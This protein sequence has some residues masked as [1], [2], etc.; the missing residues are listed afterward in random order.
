MISPTGSG[1]AADLLDARGH[2]L[3]LRLGERQPVDERRVAAVFP[4]L[5]H[6]ALV[7]R[8]G[9][10]PTRRAMPAAMAESAAFFAPVVAR[11]SSRA[12]TRAARPMSSIRLRFTSMSAF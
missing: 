1:S 12:A 3:D 8:A 11:A 5:F 9:W 4:R 10:C 6:V 7:G 2:L